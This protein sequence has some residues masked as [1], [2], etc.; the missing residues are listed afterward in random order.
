[1]AYTFK[2]GDR[3]LE[4]VTV[5]RAVGR[6]G[7]GEVYYALTDS[8]K[9]IALKYLRENP[10]IELRGI[11]N[12]MNLKSPHLVT[13]YDV[14]RSPSG[15][16]FVIM[17]YVGGPSLRELLNAEAGGF[18][19]QK[20]A[21][22]LSGIGKGL[23]YLHERGIVHRDLKP[24]NIF[25]D[26]GYV[27]IGDYGLSKHIS[28]SQHSGQTVSVGTVHY[29]APEIG[30][31]SYT[32][33]IDIYALGVILFEMLTGRLPFSGS[34][35]AE[36]LMRHVRDNP[37]LSGVPAPFGPI[38]AK[39]LA[40]DPNERY[41][42][43][44]AM[45]AAV[46]ESAEVG[47][48]V[49]RFD[50]STLAHV[51]RDVDAADVA[52]T[53]TS[54]RPPLAP[55]P[56]DVRA[57]APPYVEAK[58]QRKLA[59]LNHKLEQKAAK[60][61]RKFGRPAGRPERPE[62]EG[63]LPAVNRRGQ[64]FILIAVTI[65]IALVLGILAGG[66]GATESRVAALAFMIAGGVVGPLVTHLNILSR[67]WSRSTVID[68]LAYASVA[69]LCMLPGFGIATDECGSDLG[70]C[71]VGP[72][73]AML[74]C[75]WGRRLDHGRQGRVDGWAAFWPAV[76]GLVAAKIV[77]ADDYKFTAAGV[78]AAISLLSQAAA[79][80]WPLPL[81]GGGGLVDAAKQGFAVH[82]AVPGGVGVSPAPAT[83]HA[84]A[85]PTPAGAVEIP[86][87][88]PAAPAAV[89][90]AA[91]PSFAGRTAHAGVA[92]LGKLL[93]VGGLVLAL[94][95]GP[96][97]AQAEKNDMVGVDTETL[98]VVRQEVPPALAL[99]PMIVGTVLLLAARRSGGA[100]HF[101]RGAV[102]CLLLIQA[103][104][105]GAIWAYQPLKQLF[106]ANNLDA[107]LQ[108]PHVWA[109]AP[110]LGTLLVG[111]FLLLWP[112]SDPDKPIVI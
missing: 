23:S 70:R 111:I 103:A 61:E 83:G 25:Y 65:A 40:K 104:A 38:I 68:R 47:E 36:I 39:A 33:A 86:P 51:P 56:L 66:P 67:W 5:Q 6:G 14:R 75:D 53:V 2:H 52:E 28:V 110:I 84:N 43:A 99:A 4:G 10:E 20:A 80:M 42:D 60:L 1:V 59:H 16:P 91:Q 87:L 35:M 106:A 27:K 48:C 98:R 82:G 93:L 31:G 71:I 34:S 77:D 44:D 100:G 19:V 90:V 97:V 41:P 29:M 12:V 21:F 109:L 76:I 94:G 37:D 11:G 8:G 105:A 55:P 73:A 102:G 46:M 101:V 63:V 64:I 92:F 54:P 17:E 107:A 74:L 45:L 85:S 81:R 26:D 78:T 30:S 89:V 49:A 7:F 50:V 18:S 79:S 96:F 57:A 88:P 112:K 22:F 108:G 62:M 72:L 58:L 13:I 95:H 69:G 3:P 24:A 15:D 9:Q 32:K